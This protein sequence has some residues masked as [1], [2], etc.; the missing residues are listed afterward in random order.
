MKLPPNIIDANVLLRFLLGDDEKQLIKAKAFLQKVEFGQEEA[1]LTE[2]VFAEVVW[3]LQKVYSVPRKDI[4]EKLSKVISYK[5]L[6]TIFHKEIFLDS[7]K[8]YP[9][10]TTDIQDIFLASVSKRMNLAIRTFDKTDF[11]KLNANFSEPS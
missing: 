1:L 11:K 8:H 4:S 3:V 7:L 10:T 5:G 9:D 6:K 2:I